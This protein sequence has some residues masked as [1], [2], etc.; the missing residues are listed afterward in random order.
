MMDRVNARIDV[1]EVEA[2]KRKFR[3]E[4][5]LTRIGNASL[6][7][8]AIGQHDGRSENVLW[9]QLFSLTSNAMEYSYRRV[10][11]QKEQIR[12]ARNEFLK[13]IAHGLESYPFSIRWEGWTDVPR[14]Y[15]MNT[16]TVSPRLLHV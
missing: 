15:E 3:N 10:T 13:N 1:G 2:M 16:K 6:H 12:E 7:T 5:L 8:I 14:K 4:E 9:H 11:D